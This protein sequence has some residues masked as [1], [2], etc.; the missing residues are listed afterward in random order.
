MDHRDVTQAA[1]PPPVLQ[2][3]LICD[4]AGDDGMIL[5]TTGGSVLVALMR[6]DRAAERD[7]EWLL[8]GP[9]D[10]EVVEAATELRIPTGP[11]ASVP[12]TGRP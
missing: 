12:S 5:Q 6:F 10:P 3:I 4:S 1:L 11:C 2:V 8:F 7:T 9:T